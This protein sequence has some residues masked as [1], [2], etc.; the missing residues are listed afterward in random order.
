MAR[1]FDLSR[2]P[3]LSGISVF[4]ST[5]FRTPDTMRGSQ[6]IV[7]SPINQRSVVLPPFA[8]PSNGSDV[9]SSNT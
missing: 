3:P 5:V 4:S 8:I 1:V 9:L 2:F 6:N 7:W